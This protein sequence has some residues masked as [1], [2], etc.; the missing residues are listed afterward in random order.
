MGLV[1]DVI[2]HG[3]FAGMTVVFL[4]RAAAS[5]QRRDLTEAVFAGFCGVNPHRLRYKLTVRRAMRMFHKFQTNSWMTTL[6]HKAKG[7]FIC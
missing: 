4:D 7:S 5:W 2:D 3:L 6:V 1:F